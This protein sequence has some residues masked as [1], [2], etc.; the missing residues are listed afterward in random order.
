[1][2]LFGEFSV[3]EPAAEQEGAQ[4]LIP[5][6]SKEQGFFVLKLPTSGHR[7][8]MAKQAVRTLGSFSLF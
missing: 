4:L 6:T 7:D 2:H 5:W 3:N 1:V 8:Y